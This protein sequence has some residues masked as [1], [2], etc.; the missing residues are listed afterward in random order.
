MRGHSLPTGWLTPMQRPYQSRFRRPRGHP[1]SRAEKLALV[2]AATINDADA[3]HAI[4][5]R[6]RVVGLAAPSDPN[7]TIC[8]RR[9][10][11]QPDCDTPPT[12][13]SGA[14]RIEM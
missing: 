14:V 2:R 12:R 8:A 6:K 5:S 7:G 1:D 4:F 3:V 9:E 10:Y 11:C 13:R